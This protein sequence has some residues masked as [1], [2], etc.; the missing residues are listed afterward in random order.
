MMEK[1]RK[2]K[3]YPMKK[4]MPCWVLRPA[5]NLMQLIQQR[6]SMMMINEAL[7]CLQEGII[8]ALVTGISALFSVWGFRL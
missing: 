1:R 2:G 3:R 4:S 6:V 8:S 5:K 7:I